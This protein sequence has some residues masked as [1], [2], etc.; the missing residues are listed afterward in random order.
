MTLA[1]LKKRLSFVKDEKEIKM[2]EERIAQ[3]TQKYII[4]GRIKKEE[5]KAKPKKEK[6]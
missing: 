4:M 5:P 1:N 2:L 6:K 3:K